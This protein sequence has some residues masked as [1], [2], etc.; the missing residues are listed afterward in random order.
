LNDLI[1]QLSGQIHHSNFDE[2]KN[3][4]IIKIKSVNTN[5]VTDNDF[6]VATR[7]AKLF[8]SAEQ[9][10]KQA[11]ESAIR[12]AADIQRLFSAID[13]ISEEARQARLSLER[14]IRVRKQEIRQACIQSGVDDIKTFI[15]EQSTD[16]QQIDHSPYLDRQRFEDAIK[17]K[18]GL[19]GVQQAIDET[20]QTI[21]TEILAR[22]E[23]VAR[24]AA[25]IDNQPEAYRSLFQDRQ[26]L[27]N[28]TEHE[29]QLTVDKR[30]SFFQEQ[31][32]KAKAEVAITEL[33]IV[34]EAE[35]DPGSTVTVEMAVKAA[36]EINNYRI[37]VD[38]TSTK[39]T[40][41]DLA[42]TIREQYGGHRAV[43]SI[44]LTR[45][46]DEH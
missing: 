42:R 15:E 45:Q 34:E 3:E 26:S 29:L 39:R 35:L 36:K 13:Q 4:L 38:I 27:L 44:V 30:I 41:I 37:T 11:K 32:A 28:L 5:L 21:R 18:S 33:N 20:N 14:Q 22:A 40:A 12:Q 24:S 1:I 46:N 9:A 8:K 7:H 17:G 43:S 23:V 19:R 31:Q 10:L 25:L 16:F 6:V 2:W